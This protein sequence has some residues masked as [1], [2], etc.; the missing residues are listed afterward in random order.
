MLSD[1][2]VLFISI[3]RSWYYYDCEDD[4]ARLLSTLEHTM[5]DS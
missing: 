2:K 1:D 3:E 4:A 5:A